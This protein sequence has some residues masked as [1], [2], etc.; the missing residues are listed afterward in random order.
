MSTIISTIKNTDLATGMQVIIP[1]GDTVSI[2][3][4]VYPN[5]ISDGQIVAETSIGVLYFAGDRTS[6]VIVSE[7][8]AAATTTPLVD[9][10]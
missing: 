1:A 2:E 3:G 4:N 8:P 6:K 9:A 7:D 10:L 5:R